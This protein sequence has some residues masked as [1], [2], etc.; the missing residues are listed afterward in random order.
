MK[1]KGKDTGNERSC[2]G[3]RKAGTRTNSTTLKEQKAWAAAPNMS[4]REEKMFQEV[5]SNGLALCGPYS[6]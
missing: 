3:P 1:E 2:S 5:L 6:N 4:Y